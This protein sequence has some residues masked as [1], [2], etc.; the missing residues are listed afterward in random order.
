M[1][2]TIDKDEINPNPTVIIDDSVILDCPAVGT[3]D[4]EVIWLK[5]GE[6]LDYE[7]NRQYSL[8]A[9]GK[10][11]L[12]QMAKEADDGIYTC[13]AA[14]E[15]GSTEESFDLDVWSKFD[16]LLMW[17]L[18]WETVLMNKELYH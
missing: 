2:P 15:A 17:H 1:P 5:N 14:N 11:L 12:I 9:N 18:K 4:P 16:F 8:Q 10:R 13:V 3:P 7:N 6:P